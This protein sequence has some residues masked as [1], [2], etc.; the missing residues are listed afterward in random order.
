[1]QNRNRRKISFA[2]FPL[3]FIAAAFLMGFAVMLLWNAIV[4]PVLH[5][6]QLNYWQ[7]VGL[8]VLCR[9]LSGGFRGKPGG[10]EGRSWKGGPSWRQKWMNMSDEERTKFREQ[11][12]KRCAPRD[13]KNV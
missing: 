1:M 6:E 8:L 10:H 5:V 11:W 3:F 4:S 2:F 7:A 13:D 9:I 12:K